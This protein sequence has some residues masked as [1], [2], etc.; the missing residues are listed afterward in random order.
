MHDHDA[1]QLVTTVENTA[2]NFCIL[3]EAFIA[4]MDVSLSSRSTYRRALKAFFDWLSATQR[5]DKLGTLNRLDIL[6]YKDELGRNKRVATANMY[7]FIVRKFFAWLADNNVSPNIAKGIRGFK[8]SSGHAK[9]CLT[10]EQVRKILEG[11][12]RGN[13]CGLRNFAM[14]NLM[15]RTGLREIEVARANIGDMRDESGETVLWVHGKG[16]A[17]ADAFVVL[18]PATFDPIDKWLRTQYVRQPHEPLF[19]AL[20]TNRRAKRMTPRSISGIVKAAM[21]HVGID[22]ERLT[23]HSLRHTAISLAIAGGASLAQAQ[24]M[25]RHSKPSTTMVYFHNIKRVAEAA[26]KCVNF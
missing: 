6:A 17:E 16:R 8:Q 2:A 21:R 12:D 24:A 15:A 1:V 3:A 25:A 9:D 13:P 19:P 23:P 22:S 10:A 20:S 14:I 7:L 4:S 5:A 18:V 11:I 26:E